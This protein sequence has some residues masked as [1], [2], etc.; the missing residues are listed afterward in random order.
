MKRQN[1]FQK[2]YNK[3]RNR[4][5]RFLK[6]ATKRGFEFVENILPSIPKK[7]TEASVR[8]LERLTPN[9][10][11]KRSTYYD[12]LTQEFIPGTEGRTLERKRAAGR[13]KQPLEPEVQLPSVTHIILD[14]VIDE[15]SR[16]VPLSNWTNWF[17][18]KKRNDKNILD[19]MIRGAIN[20]EGEDEVAARLEA[21]A[22]EV[23]NL[24]Q[25]ILYGSGGGD[26]N[27]NGRDKIN[28]D[29]VRFSTILT[30]RAMTVYESAE[31]NTLVD[32]LG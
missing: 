24:L 6:N 23:N 25:E 8:R 17:S 18:E 19:R 21:H 7:I 1:P 20:S 12:K 22:E 16:C 4:I 26:A 32:D 3:Q 15:I 9:E 10:L 14:N 13:R 2:A 29:L 30:G 27:E 11:Y 31:L 28:F 5:K